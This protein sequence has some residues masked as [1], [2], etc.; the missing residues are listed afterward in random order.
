MRDGDVVDRVHE[1]PEEQEGR[2]VRQGQVTHFLIDTAAWAPSVRGTRPWRFGTR[3]STVTLHADAD[4]SLH[5]TDSGGREMLISCGAALYNL[6]LAV[7]H[8]GRRPDVRMLSDPE[9]PDLVAEVAVGPPHATTAE[10]HRLYEQI[11]RCRTH[12]GGFKPG[13][14]PIGLLQTLRE[15]AYAEKASLRVVADPRVRTALAALTEAA[16]QIQRQD[17]AYACEMARL[18]KIRGADQPSDRYDDISPREPASADPRFGG[19]DAPH[20]RDPVRTGA[21]REATGVVTLLVTGGD[22]RADWLRAGQALQRVLLC[23]AEHGV[24][25]AFHTEA[26]EVPDLRQ[27]IRARFCDGAHPQMILR[28]GVAASRPESRRR[29]VTELTRAAL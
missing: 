13:G 4:R 19:G 8:L 21:E 3:G 10:E 11:R 27:F 7:C 6:R 23:A 5:V 18:A 26:L 22:E 20:A 16:E 17:P 28:L 2:E 12:C 25:A 24:S 15:H 29:S 9:R 14:L 1:G